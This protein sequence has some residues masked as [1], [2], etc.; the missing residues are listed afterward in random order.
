MSTAHGMSWAKTKDWGRGTL[1]IAALMLLPSLAWAEDA[2]F[3]VAQLNDVGVGSGA[4]ASEA[5]LGAEADDDVLGAG[6]DWSVGLSTGVS[7]GI[8]SFVSDPYARRS[9]VRYRVGADASYTI[10][11]LDVSVGLATGFSQWLTEGGGSNTKQEFR[12]TDTYLSFS[13]GI[14]EGY[15]MDLS[16]G[17]DFTLPTSAFSR[18]ARLYTTISP[19]LIFGGDIGPMRLSYQISYSHNFHG[20]TS[21][22]F[23]ASEVDVLSRETGS[24]AVAADAVAIDGVLTEMDLSHSFM[25]RLRLHKQVSL[26]VNFGF[27]DYWTY[28]NGSVTQDDAFT[29]PFARVGRGHGQSM[30]GGVRLS[31][32]PWKYL[33]AALSMS[34]A[35]PWKTDDN[36]SYRFPFIDF[37]SP[38]NNF[39]NFGLSVMAR[40]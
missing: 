26:S 25:V 10:P 1:L 27:S 32:Q 35:Q 40:Y 36:R 17:L 29:S 30:N 38:A 37:E 14:I 20:Y 13:R 6:K 7:V 15:G 3:A 2:A 24:E 4:V 23:D 11:T 34:S 19:S 5:S 33:S 18:A 12:W 31:Y 22:V 28:D 21:M 9:R 8:G 16:A 39:T